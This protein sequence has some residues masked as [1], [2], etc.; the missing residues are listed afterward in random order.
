MGLFENQVRQGL[1]G[2]T[3]TNIKFVNTSIKN[4]SK[5]GNYFSEAKHANE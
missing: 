2:Y 1:T 3:Q 4:L 5:S